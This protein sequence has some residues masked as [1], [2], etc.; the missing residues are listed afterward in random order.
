MIE[1]HILAS[2]STGNAALFQ[3]GPTSI[4]IDAGISA[5]RIA[6]ALKAV[7]SD[8]QAI[9]AILLTHEHSDHIKGIEVLARRF[10]IPVYARART[11]ERLPFRDKIPG[12]C[13]R[14][15]D[16]YLTIGAVELECFPIPHDAVD[17]VGFT[18]YYQKRKLALA[19][20][21]GTVAGTVIDAL[22][23]ADVAVLEANHDREMLANGPY[24][25]FL[26][27]RISSGRGHLS[28]DHSAQVLARIKMKPGLRVFLAHLSQQNNRPDLARDTVADFLRRQGC[29]VGRE[30]VLYPTYPQQSVGCRV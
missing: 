28:N 22:S 6:Q 26:K 24:P 25:G 5:R 17:P 10:G 12:S 21:V 4:L 29:D 8:V 9:D 7:G 19:T 30:I 13:C 3:F 16:N 18:F 20:D 27:Q 1:V 2:G 14:L 11:W 23:M 15:L